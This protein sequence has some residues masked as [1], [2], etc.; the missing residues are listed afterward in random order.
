M[1]KEIS[2]TEVARMSGW[3]PNWIYQLLRTGRLQGR[4]V[5]GRWLVSAAS[6]RERLRAQQQSQQR[7]KR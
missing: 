6:V 2:V 4:Q 3:G 1:A 5:M 7:T